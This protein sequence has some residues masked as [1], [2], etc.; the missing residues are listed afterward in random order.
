MSVSKSILTDHLTPFSHTL[1][2]LFIATLLF[3]ITSLFYKREFIPKKDLF[4]LLICS[5]TGV[6]FNQF[7][8]IYGLSK[9]SPIDASLIV[10]STPIFV[11]IFSA[12]ILKDPISIMK[13]AGVFTGAIGAVW[14]ILSSEQNTGNSSLLGDLFVV[15][16][17][18]IYAIYFVIAKPIAQK[19]NPLTMMKWM[20]LFATISFFP[21]AYKETL[22]SKFFTGQISLNLILEVLYVIIIATYVAYMLMPIALKRIRTTTASMYNYFQPIT[23]VIISVF[24]AQDA[25][26]LQKILSALLIFLGVFLV[27][28][29][30]RSKLYK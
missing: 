22:D 14:L 8:F 25:I 2:R 4:M 3:W 15:L 5:L 17:S 11:M 1:I 27:T 24:L 6:V 21:F 7:A 19:Y 12:V 10:T 20:F 29:S 9:T 28:K 18:F 16:S 30:P 23:A 26:T 13:I